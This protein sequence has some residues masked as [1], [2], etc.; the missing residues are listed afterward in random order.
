[1]KAGC[2][3][4]HPLQASLGTPSCTGACGQHGTTEWGDTVPSGDP[5]GCEMNTAPT[6]GSNKSSKW[7]LVRRVQQSQS[8]PIVR[9]WQQVDVIDCHPPAEEAG[10][11]LGSPARCDQLCL[12]WKEP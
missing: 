12:T 1:M 10:T 3:L 11:H 9:V 4:R 7:R 6:A 8:C 2:S 5:Q